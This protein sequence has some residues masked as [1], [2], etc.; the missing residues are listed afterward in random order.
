MAAEQTLLAD[1]AIYLGAAVIAVPISKRLG[2]GS[3]VGYLIA[4]VAIGP[5][6]LNFIDDAETILHF[7]EF[8]VV[9]LLFLIGLELS[10]SRLW[11]LRHAIFGLGALQVVV[12]AALIGAISAIFIDDLA[13]VF[14]VSIALSLSSTAMAMQIVEEKGLK[15]A[16]AGQSGFAVLLFQDLAVIPVLALL[17]LMAADGGGESTATWIDFLRVVAVVAGILVGG[18]YV[19]RHI[20]RLIAN[21]EL[22][23][24]FTAFALFLVIGIA[25]LMQAVGLSMALGTFL[26]GVVLADSEYRQQL[27]IEIEPFKGLLMGL[28]FIAVGMST[29]LGLLGEQYFVIAGLVLGILALKFSVL[30]GLGRLFGLSGNQC[31]LFAGVVSQVGE[32]AF[33]IFGLA[34]RLGLVDSEISDPLIVVVSLSMLLT[35]LVIILIESIIERRLEEVTSAPS[36]E[37]QQAPII[38]IG[39]GR[40]GQVVSR[41]LTANGIAATV[42]DNDPDQIE[43]TRRYAHKAYYGDAR[44]LDLL[45]VAGIAS[46][47]LL[48]IACDDPNATLEIVDTVRAKFPNLPIAA[49]ARNR[50]H[51]YELFERGIKE[52]ERE[53]FFS[54]LALT[55]RV[56]KNMGY[57]KQDA[58][59]AVA[60]FRQHDEDMLERLFELRGEP[61]RLRQ[62]VIQSRRDFEQL[63][64]EELEKRRGVD[65]THED[66][67]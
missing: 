43:L 26:A 48:V 42:I 3:V 7:S 14:V 10:P 4:G 36:M 25:L 27:E 61:D 46:A 50:T 20:F 49:R 13:T 59:D 66:P 35:P 17:P 28:F 19:A 54:A 67:A 63:M 62:S 23:E 21:T 65:N 60:F 57:A 16:G 24:L 55:E 22:R 44:R 38:L 34:D 56:L 9:L 53:V 32:F 51:A 45:E 37:A 58:Y 40:F 39:A 2:L 18:R 15:N 47:K 1:A 52:V 8:G 41:M 29:N 33:V 30:L 5:W 64:T 12:T 11:A 31:L 6:G